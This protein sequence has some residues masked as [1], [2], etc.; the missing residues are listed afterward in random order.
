MFHVRTV[1]FLFFVKSFNKNRFL[2]RSYFICKPMPRPFP[3]FSATGAFNRVFVL[4]LEFQVY[5]RNDWGFVD[6]IF[7]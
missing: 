3:I 7:S 5:F 4:L 6:S 1:L 2:Q